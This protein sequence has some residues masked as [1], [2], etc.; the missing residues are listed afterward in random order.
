MQKTQN[1][2]KATRG[3][4]PV[5]ARGVFAALERLAVWRPGAKFG[6]AVSG[7]ADSVALL[8]LFLEARNDRRA[9]APMAIAVVHFNH[10]LRGQAADRDEKFVRQLA[11][12]HGLDFHGGRAD[13]RASAQRAK[14]NLEDA[15]RRERY[16][17]FRQL[18]EEERVDWVATAHTM[19]DQAE[20]VLAHI[21]RGTGLAGLGGIHPVSPGIVRPLL[22]VR[23]AELRGYL[24]LHEQTWR[25]DATNRD[26][27]KT[28]ARIRGKLLPLLE[29]Q[30]QP[31]VVAHLAALAERAREDEEFLD[32]AAATQLA[33][34]LHEEPGALRIGAADLLAK[35]TPPALRGRMVRRIVKALKRRDGELGAIHITAVLQLA[36]SG[37]NGKAVAVPG[38]V[39]VRRERET[40]VFRGVASSAGGAPAIEYQ[41]E[42]ATHAADAAVNIPHLKCVFRLRTIDWVRQRSETSHTWAAVDCSKLKSPLTLRNW[43]PGDRLQPA[44]RGSVHKLKR[45]LNE[46][47]VS[48]WD[49]NGW[50]VLISDGEIIWA[51]GFGEAAK[52]AAGEETRAA[53]VIEEE[54]L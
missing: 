17:F 28:R 37:Q 6:V 26:T 47:G 33:G 9:E 31:E 4:S 3:R 53:L 25:E 49:R 27:T 23:R 36:R 39:E 45:L 7:G 10:Q 35:A 11:A 54:P 22:G 18:V 44:G 5:L 30:F 20:T 19:D 51:R 52:Y 46:K 43:R 2:K 40:L 24:K 29:K 41:H 16:A 14:R 38:G 13:V 48:R 21:L 34:A 15:G 50:P 12:E 8:R 1:A 42:V 32:G